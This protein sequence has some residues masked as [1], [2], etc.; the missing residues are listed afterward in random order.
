MEAL[1]KANTSFALDF[2]KH[3]CQEDGDK[4]ILF[5]PLSISSALATVYLGAKGNTVDQMAKVLHFNKVEGARNVITTIKMQVFSRTEERLANRCTCFQKTEIGKSD[6]IHTA[7]KALNFEINQ[8]T[9][10]YLLKSVN[11]LYG[12]KSL[13]FSKEYLQLVKKYYSAEPQSVDFVGAADEI[14]REINSKVEHQT[15]GKIQN[16]LPPGSVDS[17]TRLVLINALYFKGNWATKFEAEATRQRP[18]K[19]NMHTTKPV[20]MMYLSDKFN[21]TYVESVQ[22]DVLELPYVNNDLSM[23]ILLPSDIT[24]L[25]KLEKE[26]TFENLSAWT[27]PELMEKMKMEV[28]LPR[29]TLEEKYDLKSTL[30]RMGLQDVF[31]EGQADFTGMSENG[32]LFL[33]HVFHKCYLEVNEEGTEAAAASSATLASRSLGAT[34]IFVADHPFLFFIRHNKTK[35]ILF[36]GR[37]SSP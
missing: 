18:F 16:L 37:F 17:L 31:V 21:W 25:Q 33:S 14:R 5:S 19:I 32:D 8:P 22:T 10:N 35:S 12:E 13:P 24:G 4:N 2:F 23:F 30:S 9:K 34:V 3:E 7:F 15:E 36:L 26:L 20:P 27:S 6:I 28:Y 1:N 11:Q 29:F